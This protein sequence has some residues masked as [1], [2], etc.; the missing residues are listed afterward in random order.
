MYIKAVSSDGN[1]KVY[2][3]SNF[4]LRFEDSNYLK[5]RQGEELEIRFDIPAKV[6]ASKYY[7]VAKGYYIPLPKA[8]A[9]AR[10]PRF[11]VTR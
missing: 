3:P 4:S 8:K 1:E 7:L 10:S 9:P 5:L 6:V 11:P 2:Y